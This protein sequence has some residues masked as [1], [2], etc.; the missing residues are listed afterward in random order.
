LHVLAKELI[1]Y[2][3]I[4]VRRNQKDNPKTQATLGTRQR[5]KANNT[6]TQATLGTRQRKKANNTK[7]QATLGKRQ[8]KKANNTNKNTEYRKLKQGPLKSLMS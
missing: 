3:Y 7:T 1:Y 4:N 2:G 8:R 5:K 6:K